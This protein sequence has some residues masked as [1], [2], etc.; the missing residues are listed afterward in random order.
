METYKRLQRDRKEGVLSEAQYKQALKLLKWTA[1]QA[2]R[3]G[4]LTAT[5]KQ[6]RKDIRRIT[7]WYFDIENNRPRT[8]IFLDGTRT[9]VMPE[10]LKIANRLTE[11]ANKNPR[12]A[13]IP[14]GM[15]I[16]EITA[17]VDN[18]RK[19]MVDSKKPKIPQH[20]FKHLKKHR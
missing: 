17:L 13:A 20:L 11:M 14:H 5:Q 10:F 3:P 12:I 19:N 7:R 15:L 2:I 9:L 18:R 1:K 6:I 16:A 8:P 4:K